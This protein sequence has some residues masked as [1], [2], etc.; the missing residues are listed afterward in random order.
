MIY[1]ILQLLIICVYLYGLQFVFE[2][3]KASPK[4]SLLL[5]LIYTLGIFLSLS[6]IVIAI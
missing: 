3:R 2:Y 4:L 5:M 1:I 6:L